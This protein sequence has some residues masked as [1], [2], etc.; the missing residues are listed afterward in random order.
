MNPRRRS[1]IRKAVYLVVIFALL[2]PIYWLGAPS[3]VDT[4]TMKG[5]RGGLLAQKREKNG[6]EQVYYGKIDPTSET[7]RLA[8][9][10]MRGIAVDVLWLKNI[11]YQKKKDWT[12]VSATLNQI[13]KLQPNFIDV[14]RHQG[15]NLSYNCSAEFDDYRER[16]HWV[17]KGIDF[18]KLGTT[19]NQREPRLLRDI[20]SFISRKIGRSDEHKQFRR[21]FREDDDFNGALP[22]SERDNWL[23]GKTWFR[24]A[25]DLIDTQKAST[26]GMNPIV[27]RSEAGMCQMNH[28]AAIEKEGVFGERARRAWQQAA[29]DWEEF[30][31]YA[32]P[33][34]TGLIVRLGQLDRLVGERQERFDEI[35][36]LGQGIHQKLQEERL[37][38]LT[39]AQRKAMNTPPRERTSEQFALAQEAAA[40]LDIEPQEIVRNRR[41]PREHLEKAK[42][43]LEHIAQVEELARTTKSYR[44]IVN[45]EYWQNRAEI[46]Q[47][48]EMRAGRELVFRGGEALAE[49]DLSAALDAFARGSAHWFSVLQRYPTLMTDSSTGDDLEELLEEY[50]KALDQRDEL[51]PPD[52]ALAPYIRAQVQDNPKMYQIGASMKKAD[53]AEKADDP[54]TACSFYFKALESWRQIIEDLPSLEQRSD[55]FTT[56]TVLAT[57]R[58]YAESLR[59]NDQTVPND[60]ILHRF[61]RVQMEHDPETRE[62][63]RAMER[64]EDA[65]AKQDLA[66]ARKAYEEGFARWRDILE[67]YPTLVGDG[68]LGPELMILVDG[69]RDVLKQENQEL[70]KDF[71]LQEIVDRYGQP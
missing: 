8:T 52:F 2:F 68:T 7:L 4:E 41:F 56:A 48:D 53:E 49:G 37:S 42:K 66:A 65:V 61:V 33:T 3:T 24:K 34:S 70:P 35:N 16:Y 60:F 10:G 27:F 50:G 59:K 38:Q 29:K 11:E 30:G 44:G 19:Y 14:W 6:L 28:G 62:A 63:Q 36:K 46:E 45:Y 20:A 69:Y 9:L 32:I 64:A 31:Q 13:I 71:P 17:I 58:K 12:N 40:L 43:L 5:S 57:I 1:F 15:W 51:F 25:E 47:M 26:R 18:L 23:V 54:G 67:R 21:L 39:D 22:K 55:P